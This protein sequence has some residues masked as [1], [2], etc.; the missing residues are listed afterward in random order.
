MIHPLPLTK[1]AAIVYVIIVTLRLVLPP[2]PYKEEKKDVGIWLAKTKRGPGGELKLSPKRKSIFD[3]THDVHVFCFLFFQNLFFVSRPVCFFLPLDF[4]FSFESL[5]FYPANVF[6]TTI[7]LKA[8][9]DNKILVIP[10]RSDSMTSEKNVLFNKN[11]NG[12]HSPIFFFLPVFGRFDVW[13]I[14]KITK[15]VISRPFPPPIF[16]DFRLVMY[17]VLDLYVQSVGPRANVSFLILAQSWIKREGKAK[18]QHFGHVKMFI[19]LFT[20]MTTWL[21]MCARDSRHAR[22]TSPTH[23]F[24]SILFLDPFLVSVFLLFCL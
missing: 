12:S 6:Y 19:F 4:Q 10:M 1:P 16:I 15:P 18:N 2:P 21:Q 8:W 13:T 20:R 5:L 14:K 22:N 11:R 17:K 9:K 24:I 7:D 3:S 23:F